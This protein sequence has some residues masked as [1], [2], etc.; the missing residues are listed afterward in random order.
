M[1]ATTTITVE[2]GD[3]VAALNSVSDTYNPVIKWNGGTETLT[4]S[5]V[6]V[7]QPITLECVSSS[8][9][10]TLDASAGY[11]SAQ[12]RIIYDHHGNSAASNY[13]GIVFTGG[14]AARHAGKGG[15]ILQASSTCL[16]K[17]FNSVFDQ[18]NL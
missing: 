12:F 5:Q 3:I 6:D 18:S 11:N 4:S 8:S 17:V 16:V 13:T 1:R 2:S 14:F 15:E 9:P 10:C 7:T